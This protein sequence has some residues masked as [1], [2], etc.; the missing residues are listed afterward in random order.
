MGWVAFAAVPSRAQDM[1]GGPPP[2][3][4]A[5]EPPV[6]EDEDSGEDETTTPEDFTEEEVVEEAP[7]I[8]IPT[9]VCE[10]R[11]VRQIR[12]EGNERV[13]D[14]D[15]L[16]SMRLRRGITCSDQDVS[17]DARALWDLGYFDDIVVE[18][19]RE[20]AAIDLVFRV[21]ERPAIAKIV[22]DGNDE[23]ESSDITEKVTLR[24]GSVL[25]LP[26]IR[27]NVT[28]I[29]DLYAEKGFFL[30]RVD[31]HLVRKPHNEV[32][33]HFDIV[34]GERVTVR[35][36]RFVGNRSITDS[37]ILG[38][39]QTGETGFFSFLSSSNNYRRDVFE[40]DV[41]RLQAL[42]Y[43][44]GYLTIRVGNPRIEL[45]PD[46]RNIDITV[47][48][49]EGPRYRISQLRVRELDEAGE[50]ID[51][52]EGRRAMRERIT[53]QAGDWFSRTSIA[54]D[55]MSV[56]RVY[57]DAGFARAEINP[58]TDIDSTAHTV[59]VTLT[60]RRGPE[61]H[62]ERINI[63]GNA[64]T[65]DLV[66]RREVV[67]YEGDTYSQTQLELSKARIQALGYF[68]RVDVSEEEGSTPGHIVLNFEV[69]EKSTGTFQIGAGFSSIE[70]FIFT[71]QIQQNNLFGLGHSL[72]FQA[73]VS[74]IRQMF[75]LRY[76]EPYLFDSRWT[77]AGEGFRTTRL[78]QSFQRESTGG[79]LTLGHPI[80]TD[81]LRFF[82]QY[83]AEY[84]Q[85]NERTGGLLGAGNSGINIGLRLPLANLFR[86]GLT[87][88]LRLSLTWD[89]RDNRLFPTRGIYASLSS[90]IADKVL[91]SQNTFIRHRGFLRWYYPIIPGFVLKMNTEAGLITSRQAQGVPIFERFFLG[92]ILD[93]RGFPLRT[94]G[95]RAGLPLSV[96]PNASGSPVGEPFGGNLQLFYNLEFEFP[97]LESVGLRG[98][99]FQ[100]GGNT[101]NLERNLCQ[102]PPAEAYTTYR[103]PCRVNLTDMRFSWGF[104]VRWF[105]PM[106]PLRFEWGF[107]F[108]P[109]PG[110]RAT[111]FQ[112]TIGNFF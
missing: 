89:S 80:F 33:I 69:V 61:V 99:V 95:P 13:D 84:V 83:T 7:R 1:M 34:E 46:R 26:D 63:N 50:E 14:D 105:S 100:D 25:S 16:T 67:I 21:H 23:I 45:T 4:I 65:R 56:T 37:E 64:K 82:V 72:T 87:S 109:G 18:G 97:I 74:G 102:A 48:V 17:R 81:Y 42:Y 59:G 5:S 110:E 78:F 76:V 12:I 36:I 28:K 73:Q 22:Y 111:D 68:E 47:P 19:V 85:I 51:P 91:G 58:S 90:E 107:P 38:V 24:E 27:E 98:V 3:P 49:E 2:R 112:F 39:M 9:T 44:R 8:A 104:G 101:W 86:N 75:Q 35:R 108:N 79:S 32:E 103:D 29:R 41:N 88:S 53:A 70:S 93:V 10:G 77:A 66:I 96:D 92:G 30:A 20:G 15:M 31:Y 52:L 106:G 60:I 94:L 57:R 43:D 40:E 62:I 11:P 55:L 71:A 6:E 54:R